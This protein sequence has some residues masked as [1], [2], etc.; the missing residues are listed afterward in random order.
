MSISMALVPTAVATPLAHTA[1][2]TAAAVKRV[3]SV[4]MAAAVF[5]QCQHDGNEEEAA[6]RASSSGRSL[7]TRELEGGSIVAFRCDH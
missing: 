5:A 3:S 2:A 7:R 4:G 1:A 6:L